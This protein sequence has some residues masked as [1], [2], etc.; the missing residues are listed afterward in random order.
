MQ[1]RLSSAEHEYSG[2]VDK[3]CAMPPSGAAGAYRL[4]LTYLRRPD[5]N[6]PIKV[7]VIGWGQ[8]GLMRTLLEE[9]DHGQ[10]SLPVSSEGM[11]LNQHSTKS[12]LLVNNL[13]QSC[14]CLTVKHVRVRS[15]PRFHLS[16]WYMLI[17][18]AA[19]EA[20]LFFCTCV[21]LLSCFRMSAT[22]T[23]CPLCLVHL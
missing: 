1:S 4:P 5:P 14:K 6:R 20:R 7:L 15:T 22:T 8:Q 21:L 3:T 16:V 2:D 10:Q 13:G 11:F 18:P 9:L 12:S 23:G 19:A 17:V